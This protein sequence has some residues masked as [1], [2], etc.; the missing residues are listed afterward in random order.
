MLK[1]YLKELTEHSFLN[2]NYYFRISSSKQHNGLRRWTID[3]KATLHI[4]F[5]LLLMDK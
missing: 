5:S 1:Q 2:I 3:R 4:V